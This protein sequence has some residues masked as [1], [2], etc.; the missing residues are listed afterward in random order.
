M[1]R[2]SIWQEINEHPIS[3][4][5]CIVVMITNVILFARAFL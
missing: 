5:V 2:N 4:L 1:E 3:F